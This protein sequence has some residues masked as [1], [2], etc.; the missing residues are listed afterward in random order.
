MRFAAVKVVARGFLISPRRRER[1]RWLE[2]GLGKKALGEGWQTSVREIKFDTFDAV[3]GK[4]NDSRSEGLAVSDHHREILEGG[5]FGSTQA[6]PFGP[7][8]KDHSPKLFSRIAQSRNHDGAGKKR[9]A[10]FGEREWIAG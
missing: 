9:F 8:R 2:P 10:S 4:E 7:E 6:K 1:G 3:H 5:E